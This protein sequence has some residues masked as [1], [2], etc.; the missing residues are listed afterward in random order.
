MIA[1]HHE[2]VMNIV[3]KNLVPLAGVLLLTSTVAAGDLAA[4]HIPDQARSYLFNVPTSSFSTNPPPSA[5]EGVVTIMAKHFTT[6]NHPGGV[7]IV[8][9]DAI[10]C[11]PSS[12]TGKQWG[13]STAIFG[14]YPVSCPSS[15]RVLLFGK[16]VPLRDLGE[17]SFEPQSSSYKTYTGKDAIRK[18]KEIGLEPP[19][20]MDQKKATKK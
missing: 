13:A 1:N 14:D 20:D 6:K 10:V 18:L 16:F 2:D 17:K 4:F 11:W 7:T 5:V 15:T 12:P 19:E 8:F 3:I 9:Q